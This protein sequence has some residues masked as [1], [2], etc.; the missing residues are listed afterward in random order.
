MITFFFRYVICN[1]YR[2]CCKITIV[3][4]LLM[5][6]R[7]P[8]SVLW[9]KIILLTSKKEQY[10]IILLIFNLSD[11]RSFCRKDAIFFNLFQRSSFFKQSET[12][13]CSVSLLIFGFTIFPFFPINRKK[14]FTFWSWF[15]GQSYLNIRCLSN[16]TVV[17][18]NV[19]VIYFTCN[20]FPWY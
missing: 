10:F 13:R 19:P 9:C 18:F 20:S 8:K 7:S 12:L 1:M 6:C 17:S 5:K 3:T 4:K 11:T 15:G 2:L 16:K 14:W